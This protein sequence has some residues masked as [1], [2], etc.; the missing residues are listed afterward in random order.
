MNSSESKPVVVSEICWPDIEACTNNNP[1]GVIV[2]TEKLPA[3]N[4]PRQA[5]EQL[6]SFKI[7]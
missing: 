1:F 7:V 4:S 5:A 6:F 3:N 2:E